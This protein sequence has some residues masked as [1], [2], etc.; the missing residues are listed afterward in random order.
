[1]T[2]FT[3]PEKEELITLEVTL[4]EADLILKLREYPF[5]KIVV[6]KVDNILVRIE[7]RQMLLIKPIKTEEVREDE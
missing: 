1:M 3:P 6:H 2:R 5:G 7:P 4:R